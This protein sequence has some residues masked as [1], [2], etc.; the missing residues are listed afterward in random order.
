MKI[1]E[2]GKTKIKAPEGKVTKKLDI[3]YNPDKEFDRDISVLFLKAT[4]KKKVLDL[5]A[6]S[7]ARGIRLAKEAN[8]DVW[9]NDISSNAIELIEENL[10]INNIKPL[11]ITNLR[12]DELLV[13]TKEKF[14]FIDIDPFGSPI[15]FIYQAIPRL[16]K[17]GILAVTATD[18]ACLFGV[19]PWTCFRKYGSFSIKTEF[20]H[21]IALRILAKAVI[22]IGAKQNVSLVP[23]FA[24]STMHYYR[25][26]FQK[27]RS[28]V[29]ENVLENIGFIYYCEKCK[30]RFSEKFKMK[31]KCVCGNE[32]KFTGPIYVGNLWNT[33]L[34]EKMID[35]DEEKNHDKFLKTVLEESKINIPYFYKIYELNKN[36]K[37]K[38][39]IKD[40]KE[41]GFQ[42]SRTHFCGDC[43]KTNY[44]R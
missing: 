3:F 35:V 33:E 31:E 20:S 6:A 8:A 13:T 16:E 9:F 26:Y 5:M 11:K 23:I 10:K 2:E 15:T 22:E 32:L 25:I 1:F 34:I 12:A 40:L 27:I 30:K 36:K 14:D 42:A 41:K 4:K 43:I 17:N 39:I 18:T 37:I 24:H 21:E 38:N 44:S 19:F 7:G 28:F 29:K